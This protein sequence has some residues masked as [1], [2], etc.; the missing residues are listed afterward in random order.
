[1]RYSAS[2]IVLR[3]DVIGWDS[4][5]RVRLADGT[6]VTRFTLRLTAERIDKLRRARL[7]WLLDGVGGVEAVREGEQL[8]VDVLDDARWIDRIG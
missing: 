4:A 2:G 8:V 1:M 5:A 3:Q 6:V 7:P